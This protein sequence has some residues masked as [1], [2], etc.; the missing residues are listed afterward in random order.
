MERMKRI[1]RIRKFLPADG[2]FGGPVIDDKVT[3]RNRIE[4]MPERPRSGPF[5]PLPSVSPNGPRKANNGGPSGLI[6][7]IRF[8]PFNPCNLFASKLKATVK[9]KGQKFFELL[10]VSG[11]GQR[12]RDSSSSFRFL[13]FFFFLFILFCLGPSV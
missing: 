1:A 7:S 9:E 6:R 12:R 10:R 11:T 2:R 3:E 13:A 8:N 4:R 5:Y